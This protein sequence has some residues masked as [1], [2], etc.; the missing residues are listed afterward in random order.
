VFQKPE[1]DDPVGVR[2]CQAFA[3]V[4]VLLGQSNANEGPAILALFK[5]HN[6]PDKNLPCEPLSTSKLVTTVVFVCSPA[7]NSR[8]AAH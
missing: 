8:D 1:V 4:L 5:E 3:K 6:F 2:Q 7:A